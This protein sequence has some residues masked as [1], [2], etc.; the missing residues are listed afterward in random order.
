MKAG[1]QN[2]FKSSLIHQWRKK[3]RNSE[4]LRKFVKKSQKSLV[5]YCTNSTTATHW[6]TISDWEE[7]ILTMNS[8]EQFGVCKIWEDLDIREAQNLPR[9]KIKIAHRLTE[10]L[11][12]E[13]S[14]KKLMKVIKALRMISNFDSIQKVKK[15]NKN[16]VMFQNNL[17]IERR[18]LRLFKDSRYRQTLE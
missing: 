14:T 16:K 5:N 8:V 2:S 6:F 9:S 10:A 1:F 17:Q 15:E 3:K 7:S 18:T 12:K 11:F 4:R 13:I